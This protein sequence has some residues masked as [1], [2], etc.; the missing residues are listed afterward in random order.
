M[1][2]VFSLLMLFLL[3]MTSVNFVYGT[4]TDI[5]LTG[6]ELVYC[7]VVFN[8]TDKTGQ[9]FNE[10]IN[11]TLTDISMG[12]T[13]YCTIKHEE[14]Y[15]KQIPYVLEVQAN[16]TYKISI[17]FNQ[18][19]KFMLVNSDGSEIKSFHATESGYTFNWD[20]VASDSKTEDAAAANSEFEINIEDEEAYTVFNNFLNK[21][22]HIEYSED[23]KPFLRIYDVYSKSRAV[24]Y[25]EY[26]GGTQEEWLEMT[27]FEQFLWYE[28][29][30]R[31]RSYLA[32]GQYDYFFG[33][34]EKFLGQ[35]INTIYG[36]MKN[37]GE[38][39]AEAFK[40][41]ML[42]QYNYIKANGGPYNFMAGFHYL[43][44]K[45][46]LPSNDLNSDNE[47][48]SVQD[49]E[50]EEIEENENNEEV[51]EEKGIWTDV[52]I[53]LKENTFSIILLFILL[54]GLGIVMFIKNRRNIDASEE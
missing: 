36:T 12:K 35:N 1:K 8:I 29:Y 4:E 5:P 37:Y 15:G 38:E 54:C 16:T 47:E 11:V 31:Q 17:H 48:V 45:E 10:D 23:W 41:I 46:E 9:S 43:K 51:S 22:K 32:V 18:S 7:T 19:D 50:T 26:C 3:L 27:T 49:T 39:E 24:K 30:L 6:K 28:L 44:A 13:Y 25:V 42:W 52:I 21:I 33:S 14:H 34:E 20:I 53:K 40:E 2:R